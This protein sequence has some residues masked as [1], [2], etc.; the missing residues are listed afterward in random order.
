M[1]YNNYLY[2]NKAILCC[3]MLVN[4]AIGYLFMRNYY[5]HLRYILQKHFFFCFFLV[6]YVTPYR[7]N[8]S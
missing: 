1:I 4:I 7:Y 6:Q 5:F 2:L 3:L 8:I